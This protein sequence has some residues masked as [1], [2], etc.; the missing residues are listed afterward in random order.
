MGRELNAAL[1]GRSS[2][3]TLNAALMRRF[4]S[5]VVRALRGAV[6]VHFLQCL[7]GR[8]LR[9]VRRA[10]RPSLHVPWLLQATRGLA[11]ILTSPK[12]RE[13][14]G[15]LGRRRR[16][17]LHKPWLVVITTMC[18]G[19]I[20]MGR[21]CYSQGGGAG[22]SGRHGDYPGI[23]GGAVVHRARKGESGELHEL[24]PWSGTGHVARGSQEAVYR[25]RSREGY[26]RGGMP[27]G[28]G[29]D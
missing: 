2:T 13:K 9:F 8:S 22:S 7:R 4:S 17:P 14:W 12:T 28:C 16:S 11:K 27:E 5:V 15:T 3:T 10:R 21:T 23:D 24:Q 29:C 20:T 19:N 26:G 1:K 25:G 6:M 18:S